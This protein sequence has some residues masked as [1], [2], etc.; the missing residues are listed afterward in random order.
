MRKHKLSI[1]QLVSVDLVTAE[2]E[3]TQA[4][5]DRHADLSGEC[6]AADR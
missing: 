3:F 4:S 1:D 5:A 6:V 2:G